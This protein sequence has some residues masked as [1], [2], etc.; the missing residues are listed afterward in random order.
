MNTAIIAFMITYIVVT[1]ASVVVSIWDAKLRCKYQEENDACIFA[2][3]R[4]LKR[5]NDNLENQ[6][7]E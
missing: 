2:L 6:K 3:Y 4:E 1:L 7:P 5:Y